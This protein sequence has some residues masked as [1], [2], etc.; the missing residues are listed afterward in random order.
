MMDLTQILNE[1]VMYLQDAAAKVKPAFVILV[2]F[3]NYVLF[4][5]AAYIP[6]AAAL[7]GAML[8]DIITKYYA[9][10]VKSNGIKNAIKNKEISSETLWVGSRRKIISYLVVMILC[11]LSVRVTMLVT[12]AV[13][14][15]TIAYSIMFL[16]ESQSVI[17][18]LIDAGHTDLEWLLFWL[19]KKEETVL[20]NNTQ[21]TAPIEQVIIE[22]ANNITPAPTQGGTSTPTEGGD[23]KGDADWDAR[24]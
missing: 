8:L 6:A 15:S 17:E 21:V 24:I 16:R 20:D 11:G 14:L 5:D 10:S 23:V 4:P 12:V 22:K 3:L 7:G 18:N 13:F 19:R 2:S 1:V 9:L